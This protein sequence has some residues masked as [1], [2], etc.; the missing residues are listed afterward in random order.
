MADDTRLVFT[1][2]SQE[3]APISTNMIIE[4]LAAVRA[5]NGACGQANYNGTTP[6]WRNR[7]IGVRKALREAERRGAIKR[8]GVGPD[9]SLMW[10]SKALSPVKCAAFVASEFLKNMEVSMTLDPE[11]FAK[12]MAELNQEEN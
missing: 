5:G 2:I 9:G 7:C 1:M 6:S 8:L 3:K 4:R 12:W 10:A 11:E